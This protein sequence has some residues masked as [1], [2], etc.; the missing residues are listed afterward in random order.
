MKGRVC[1]MYLRDDKGVEVCD[2]VSVCFA[3]WKLVT[4]E[5]GRAGENP[6][7]LA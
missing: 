5:D 3:I 1:L 7:L 2:S 6:R 4:W